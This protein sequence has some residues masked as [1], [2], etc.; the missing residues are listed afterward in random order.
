MRRVYVGTGW[1]MN[2]TVAETLSYLAELGDL[3][4]YTKEL[5]IFVVPPFT[6]LW[7]ANA[8]LKG[9][10][11]LV[12]A[13]NMHWAKAGA[14][15]GEI[16]AQML[17]ECGCQLVEIGH[18]ERRR[19]CGETDETV[20]LKLQTAAQSGLRPILCI[21]ETE[22]QKAAGRSETVLASQLTRALHGICSEKISETIIAYE[23]IWAIGTGIPAEPAYVNRIHGWLRA[24]LADALGAD[25]AERTSIIYGGSVDV[26]STPALI[27]QPEVDGVFVG[28]CAWQAANF[29][30]IIEIVYHEVSKGEG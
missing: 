12:G 23:P 27:A 18:S 13:Q 20:N 3:S 14:Y 2:K 15:T 4:P 10:P 22:E 8:S 1:K 21:G 28:T 5:T 26:E 16:S 9:S 7:A 24:Y 11:V 29:R 6:S 19:Y 30:K 25:V 17:V